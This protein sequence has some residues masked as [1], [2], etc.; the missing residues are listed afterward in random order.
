MCYPLPLRNAPL[1]YLFERKRRC[2]VASICFRSSAPWRES[3]SSSSYLFALFL[4]SSPGRPRL[5]L[6][7]QPFQNPHKAPSIHSLLARPCIFIS[8]FAI[9]AASYRTRNTP[10]FLLIPTNT[11][12]MKLLCTLSKNNQPGV[13]VG[14][15][16]SP[17]RPSHH[18]YPFVQKTAQ[19][20]TRIPASGNNGTDVDP[21]PPTA[22]CSKS[23]NED[24]DTSP[25]PYDMDDGGMSTFEKMLTPPESDTEPQ[26]KSKDVKVFYSQ[27]QPHI[28]VGP[29]YPRPPNPF[30][31]RKGAFN[32][33]RNVIN[34]RLR[35]AR[36]TRSNSGAGNG[37][38]SDGDD[39]D[40][41]SG[42][43]DQNDKDSPHGPNAET[44]N[45]IQSTSSITA[46]HVD[47]P[48]TP[49][50][51]LRFQDPDSD[52]DSQNVTP[53]ALAS[54]PKPERKRND[55]KTDPATPTQGQRISKRQRPSLG[56]S[57]SP[58]MPPIKRTRGERK[59]F[60]SKFDHLI[61]DPERP[62]SVEREIVE[63]KSGAKGWRTAS[64]HD[65][66]WGGKPKSE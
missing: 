46:S 64:L 65:H 7:S 27:W 45:V 32:C 56:D 60:E 18:S 30:K 13:H 50:R 66:L 63:I 34:A 55:L 31:E 44:H 6:L 12:T 36:N 20:L 54:K 15:V 28:R 10:T 52:S 16:R 33:R 51:V 43:D 19:D 59:K 62:G 17:I 57:P 8:I 11:T 61:F 40:D 48:T 25:G 35:R 4:F 24:D 58:P 29:F 26:S 41:G 21:P 42:N 14:N 9:S 3:I 47:P 5:F 49:R 23:G 22:T 2:F 39:E 37:N 1:A 53:K 38:G